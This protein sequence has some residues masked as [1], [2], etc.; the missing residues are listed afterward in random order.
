MCFRGIFGRIQ[1]PSLAYVKYLDHHSWLCAMASQFECFTMQRR[2]AG[3]FLKYER[4]QRKGTVHPFSK[5]PWEV[6]CFRLPVG[7]RGPLHPPPCGAPRRGSG[8]PLTFPRGWSNLPKR[9]K[10]R[11]FPSDLES[12]QSSNIH[13]FFWV[14][15]PNSDLCRLAG[16]AF[17]VDQKYFFRVPG[18]AHI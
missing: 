10:C 3:F 6:P 8:G 11:I 16:K 1:P 14:C 7:G 17:K 9:P 2:G 4:E 13:A 5:V 12:P 18:G 15:L